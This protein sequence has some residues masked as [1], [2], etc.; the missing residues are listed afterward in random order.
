LTWGRLERVVYDHPV[1]L[2]DVEIRRERRAGWSRLP[3]LAGEDY[4]GYQYVG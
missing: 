4:N 2:V 3:T 1:G